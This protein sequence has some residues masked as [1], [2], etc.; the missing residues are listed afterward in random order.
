MDKWAMDRDLDRL[1]EIELVEIPRVRAA[2]AEWSDDAYLSVEMHTLRAEGEGLRAR[3]GLD[4]VA[5]R[6][7]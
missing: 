1:V 4:D 6:S 5:R 7:A 2:L 3:L